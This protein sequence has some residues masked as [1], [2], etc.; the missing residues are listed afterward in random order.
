M[1]ITH[2]LTMVVLFVFFSNPIFAQQEPI[3]LMLPQSPYIA[4]PNPALADA[5]CLYIAIKL[6]GAYSDS[7]SELTTQVEQ[8]VKVALRD[9]DINII[10]TN[11]DANSP[12]AMLAKKRFGS[13]S[14]LR[15][16]P[17]NVPEL[18]I[19]IDLLNLPDT[20]QCVFRLQTSF[21]KRAQLENGPK[22]NMMTDVW[23]DEPV[24]RLVATKDLAES[25]ISAAIVQTRAFIGSWS[26]T[27]AADKQSE[28]SQ[29]KPSLRK[30]TDEND[31]KPVKQQDV[32]AKYV[33]SKNSQIFHKASCPSA[34]RISMG[35][36][37]SYA[38][39][40]E[41]IAAG[42]KPCERCNP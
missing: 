1:R 19:E 18:R 7:N 42:K 33:S 6:R 14:N 2:F 12:L 38:T 23:Q 40:D 30:T 32:E 34:K 4:N 13:V 25:L 36:L 8:Q 39:R 17:A 41:A 35:N 9:Y 28:V 24:M 3:T 37:V 21:L 16:K 27:R 5:N 31:T 15:W 20:D 22:A 11:V 10:D 29:T 26:V